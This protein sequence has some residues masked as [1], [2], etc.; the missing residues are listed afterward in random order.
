MFNHKHTTRHGNV[1]CKN[2]IY[3][4]RGAKYCNRSRRLIEPNVIACSKGK[5][6]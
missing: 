1:K 6:Y 4:Q 2:C 3:K 5:L